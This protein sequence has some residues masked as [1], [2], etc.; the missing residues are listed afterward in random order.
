[1]IDDISVIV[2]EFTSVEPMAIAEKSP[3]NERNIKK[4]QSISFESEMIK[5]KTIV[6]NDPHRGS[7]TKGEEH[8][9]ILEAAIQV[10]Q[11]EEGDDIK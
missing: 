7:I 11:E 6:R 2:I 8:N 10:M 4:F 9:E 5:Q 1:M 3:R